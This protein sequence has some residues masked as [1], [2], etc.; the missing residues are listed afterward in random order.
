MFVDHNHGEEGRGD[1]EWG[2][3]ELEHLLEILSGHVR[4]A[5]LLSE[6]SFLGRLKESES[7]PG[8]E[9]ERRGSDRGCDPDHAPEFEDDDEDH[10]GSDSREG[11]RRHNAEER[12]ESGRDAFASFESEPGGEHVSER[13]RKHHGEPDPCLGLGHVHRAEGA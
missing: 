3:L 11:H 9:G 4:V 1:E 10:G 7:L 6:S 13:G 12:S 8:P 5:R 2:A